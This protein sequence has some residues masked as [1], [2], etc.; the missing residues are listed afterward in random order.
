MQSSASMNRLTALALANK[1]FVAGDMTAAEAAYRSVVE[2]VLR[3][4]SP[5]QSA[6]HIA[7]DRWAACQEALGQH[8]SAEQT[9]DLMRSV[10]KRLDDED[11][12]SKR[13]DPSRLLQPTASRCAFSY[14]LIF[15]SA[16][17]D[18]HV[19]GDGE[20]RQLREL[21]KFDDHDQGWLELILKTSANSEA[22]YPHFSCAVAFP[23]TLGSPEQRVP[24]LELINAMNV[25]SSATSVCLMPDSGRIEVRARLG[26]AGFNEAQG[27]LSDLD[28]A[29]GEAALNLTLEVLGTAQTGLSRL[30]AV[31]G[32]G[33]MPAH[34][35]S[36]DTS[37]K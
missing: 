11:A 31:C 8:V 28:W 21:F 34:S 10:L 36:T 4:S 1:L 12:P 32:G 15:Q 37:P 5:S 26:F 14:S 18:W 19:S 7:L 6:V 3:S 20:V 22:N 17:S 24:L 27:S 29:Q 23:W 33:L 35:S 25:E 16:G 13:L 2:D 9:R 30:V